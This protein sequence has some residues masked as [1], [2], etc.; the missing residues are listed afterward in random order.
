VRNGD[1][2]LS[3]VWLPLSPRLVPEKHTLIPHYVCHISLMRDRLFLQVLGQVDSTRLTPAI[4]IAAFDFLFL[5][6][7]LQQ[8]YTGLFKKKYTLSKIYF[9]KTTDAKSMS[10]V[11]MERKSLKVLMSMIWSGASLRLWLLL[12]VTC[13]DECGKSWIIDLTSVAS[14]V[15][16]T[17]SACKVW[18]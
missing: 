14:H 17:S 5:A 3:T 15:G 11:R 8:Q 7:S 18:K 9:T 4:C 13:C 6:H 12:P 10:C 1:W 2:S 16:L